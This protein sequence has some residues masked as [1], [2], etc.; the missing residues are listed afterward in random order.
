[1]YQRQKLRTD[2]DYQTNQ[3]TANQRWQANNKDYW[4]DYRARNPEY[5]IRN[6]E[7]TRQRQQQQRNAFTQPPQQ[8]LRQLYPQESISIKVMSLADI[9]Y[10]KGTITVCKDGFVSA[11]N[12]L[13]NNELQTLP[14]CLQRVDVIVARAPPC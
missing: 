12:L 10:Q 4:K 6:R 11:E 9:I 7:Q 8:R 3:K 5:V 14:Q 1:M 13:F 2:Q